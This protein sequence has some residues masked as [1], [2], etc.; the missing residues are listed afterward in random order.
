MSDIR[1]APSWAV[2]ARDLFLVAMGVFVFNI[3]IGLLNGADV[4]TFDRNQLLTHVHAGTIGWLTLTIVA[5]SFILFRA[6]DRRLVIAL[7][8]L[9]PLYVAAF[10]TGSFALRAV[11]GT[12]LLIAIAWLLVWI[13]RQFLA[14]SDRCRGSRSSSG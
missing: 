5:S 3:A 9:V 4:V 12:L 13:W 1:G 2:A 8:I 7:T 11:G 14:A 10:Y 6:A